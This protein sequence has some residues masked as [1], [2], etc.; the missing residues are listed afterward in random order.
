M[1][2]LGWYHVIGFGVL[3]PILAYRQRRRQVKVGHPTGPRIR[4]YRTGALTLAVFGAFSLITASQQKLTLFPWSI[5]RPWL[6]VPVSVGMYL[7]AVWFMRPRWRRA[8]ERRTSHVYYFMPGTPLER[9]W[10]TAVSVL[11][12]ISEEITWRGVQPALAAYVVGSPVAGALASAISFGAGHATQ[13]WRSAALIVLFALSF[14]GL[15]WLSGS[16]VL[17]M[18]VHAAY[19]V[20]AGLTYGRLGR[21]LGYDQA[22]R[23]PTPPQNQ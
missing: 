10:W 4:Q 13:G 9:R 20:T 12:G 2:L 5:A 8:V 6:S 17:A 22:S 23:T 15:V 14:Q 16:L 1:T 18:A 3:V 11:A 7:V 21:E 19:D